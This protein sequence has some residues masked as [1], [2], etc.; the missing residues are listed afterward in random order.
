MSGRA[1][2]VSIRRI[3]RDGT[4]VDHDLV[5]TEAPL[6]VVLTQPGATPVQLGLLMRTPG[7]DDDLVVGFLHAEGII[8]RFAEI[9]S[10]D[11]AEDR[12]VVT[13]APECDL[14]TTI[15]ARAQLVSSACGLC[16]R[17]ELAALDRRHGATSGMRP[18]DVRLIASVPRQLQPQQAVFA[19]TGGLHAAALF[20]T[21][22]A[23]RVLREDVGRHNAVD[24]AIG[25]AL[26]DG[27]PL[28]DCWLAVSG[29]VAY[30]IVQKAAVAAI[31]VVI[32]IGAPSDLAVAAARTGGITL[33]GFVR[34]ERFN[35]YTHP[36]RIAAAT[37]SL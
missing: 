13:L 6:S 11:A 21:R 23:I 25:A 4:R 24:K 2:V 8:S 34:D 20:D 35:V 33:I 1:T 3:D 28:Q 27:I 15:A 7:H 5:A 32:A 14:A 30:E 16:G 9:V 10:L 36:D 18:I 19:E 12:I 17:L 29:R 31:P 22:G 37:T 26:R